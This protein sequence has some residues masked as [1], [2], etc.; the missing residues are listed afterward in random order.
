MR[1]KLHALTRACV[2]QQFGSMHEHGCMQ[3]SVCAAPDW[4][5]ALRSFLG[6]TNVHMLSSSQ[7]SGAAGH[8][9][10]LPVPPTDGQMFASS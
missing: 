9:G 4:T 5:L 7:S 3:R 10:S 1:G 6:E 8:T 2:C